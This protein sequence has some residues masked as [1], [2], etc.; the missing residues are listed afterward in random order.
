MC[1][2]GPASSVAV[3]DESL[4][5]ADDLGDLKDVRLE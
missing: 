4:E 2:G 3:L 5:I 1:I